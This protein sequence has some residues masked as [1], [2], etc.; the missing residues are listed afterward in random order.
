MDCITSVYDYIEHIVPKERILFAEPMSRHTTFRVGGEAESVI[1]IEN[2]EEI[3]KLVPYFERIGQEFFI[4]GNGSNLL[5]GDKGYR[6]IVLKLGDGMKKITVQGER[7]R[8]QAGAL[9]SG[10]AAAAR[11]AGLTGFEFAAGIPGSVGGGIVMNAGAYDGEMKQITESVRVMDNEG[12][13]L[14]LDNDTM[15]FG[16]RTS[17]VKNRHFI[18]L[19]AVFKLQKGDKEEIQAKMYELMERRKS[20]QPLNYPS[21]GSTFKR[22]EGYYAGKLIMDSGMRGYRIGG[23]QVSDKHCGFIINTGDATALDIK[24][25]IEEVQAKVKERTQ[26]T[27]EPE[28]VFLGDF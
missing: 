27:L 7:M 9:L 22:P 3:R 1:L 24:E 12:E 21:A 28:I 8:V 17:V 6:G 10:A 16:Y 18:V 15:E 5:V 19:E 11:D 13:I 26:V 23:A 4:L 25:V 14:T 2:E 20:K